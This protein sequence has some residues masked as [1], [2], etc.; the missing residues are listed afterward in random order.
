[1][2]SLMIK[3]VVISRSIAL[4]WLDVRLIYGNSRWVPPSF[5]FSRATAVKRDW[6]LRKS[7]NR[8]YVI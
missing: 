4:R 5:L 8:P 1:M 7:L 6:K 2:R 3:S